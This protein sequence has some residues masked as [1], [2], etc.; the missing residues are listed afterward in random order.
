MPTIDATLFGSTTPPLVQV[1]VNGL[2]GLT[3]VTVWAEPPASPRRVVR[4]GAQQDPTSDALVLYDTAPELGVP[5]IYVVEYT[6]GSTRSQLSA[7]AVTVPDPG[8]HVL[9]DPYTGRAVLVDLVLTDDEQDE[10]VRGT[11]LYPQG[12]RR[13]VALVDVRSAPSGQ[14]VAYTASPA[15]VLDLLS[16]GLPIVSR[17]PADG[18]DVAPND[19][20]YVQTLTHR[21]RSRAGDRFITLAYE[22]VVQPDP[23]LSVSPVT[24]AD[25]DAWYA[26]SGTLADLDADYATLLDIARADWGL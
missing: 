19:V 6:S 9:S 23:R 11:V 1:T 7:A 2:T 17:H 13:G 3:D 16:S 22:S 12:V 14:L 8:R 25:I 10:T 20:I 4:G 15:E 26:P 24:L 5:I 18:C 21:R